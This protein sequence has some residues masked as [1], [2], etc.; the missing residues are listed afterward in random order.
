MIGIDPAT[1]QFYIDMGY[2]EPQISKAFDQSQ[3]LG[4]DVL[5]ALNLPP[6]AQLAEAPSRP[7]QMAVEPQASINNDENSFLT[8]WKR[9]KQ[10]DY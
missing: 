8:P 9:I 7:Q 10:S 4:I 2:S 5:D 6:D 3:R 1:R